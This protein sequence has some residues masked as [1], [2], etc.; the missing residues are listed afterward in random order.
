MEGA[1]DTDGID[2]TNVDLG[3]DFP[4]GIFVCHTAGDPAHALVSAYEDLGLTVDTTYDPRGRG[5]ED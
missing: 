2:V 4:Y 3:P 1:K 5:D